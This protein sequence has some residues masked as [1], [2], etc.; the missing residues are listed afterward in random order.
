MKI[1]ID[2]VTGGFIVK[3]NEQ[4]RVYDSTRMLEMFQE[5]IKLAFNKRVKVVNN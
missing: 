1:Q 2:E 3:L 5:I 4:V